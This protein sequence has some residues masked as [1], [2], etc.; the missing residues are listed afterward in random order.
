MVVGVGDPNP[1]VAE[2]G[3]ATVR[4]AGIEVEMM[5]GAEREACYSINQDFMERMQAQALAQQQAAA[6][7][8][9]R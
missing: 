2:Q 6:Q 3:I 7:A 1:L 4:S 5:D 9:Q 8:P